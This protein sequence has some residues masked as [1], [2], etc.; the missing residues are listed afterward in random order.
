MPLFFALRELLSGNR[1]HQA[2]VIL[3]GKKGRSNWIDNFYL[4]KLNYLIKQTA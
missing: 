1:H 2:H 4:C 3:C